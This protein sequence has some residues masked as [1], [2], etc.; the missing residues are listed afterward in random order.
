ME[1]V[2]NRMDNNMIKKNR[3]EQWR[4]KKNLGIGENVFYLHFFFFFYL[5]A[6]FLHISY[7]RIVKQK[8]RLEEDKPFPIQALVF[9]SL[10]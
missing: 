2:S 1:I 3:G 6:T 4:M 9:T 7:F 8:H 5:P 10:Q